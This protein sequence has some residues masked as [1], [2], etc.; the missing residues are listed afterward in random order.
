MLNLRCLA[1]AC[2]VAVITVVGV[3]A[4]DVVRGPPESCPP[5][6]EAVS[7]HR[8]SFCEP[9]P[10]ANCPP[11]HLPKVYRT[12]AYCEPPPLEACPPGSFY[13]SKSPTDTYCVAGEECTLQADCGGGEC[14]DTSFCIRWE[15]P[16]GRHRL[17]VA[18]GS[19]AGGQVCPDG[20]DCVKARRCERTTKRVAS[21][22]SAAVPVEPTAVPT[23]PPPA[24][25]AP[26]NGEPSASPRSGASSSPKKTGCAGC[27]MGGSRGGAGAVA[28]A[29]A[30]SLL[31]L[32]RCRRRRVGGGR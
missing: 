6:H 13:A 5:G 26:A 16:G 7:S 29:A 32:A 2:A 30:V 20:Q 9:P 21:S 17:A 18:A 15:Y 12:L 27:T 24:T 31:G 8:G 25:G 10:P 28:L 3:A 23:V 22:P 11:E 1:G 19:C 14:I 4:A